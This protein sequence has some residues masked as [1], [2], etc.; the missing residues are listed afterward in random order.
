VERALVMAR[1]ARLARQVVV[2]GVG[3]GGVNENRFGRVVSSVGV[4]EV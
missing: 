3:D 1:L 4:L 2:F